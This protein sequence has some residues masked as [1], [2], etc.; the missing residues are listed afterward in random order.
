MHFKSSI[1]MSYLLMLFYT[2]YEDV[3]YYDLPTVPMFPYMFEC[4]KYDRSQNLSECYKYFHQCSSSYKQ[5]TVMC[6][7]SQN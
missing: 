2:V 4:Y 5:L 3:V 7:G 1:N 6:E